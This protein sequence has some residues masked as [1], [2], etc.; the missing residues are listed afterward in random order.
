MRNYSVSNILYQ[1]QNH[2]IFLRREKVIYDFY[3]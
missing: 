3:K 1:V 2:T